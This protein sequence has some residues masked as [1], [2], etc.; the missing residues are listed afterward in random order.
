M[1][2]KRKG[3]IGCKMISRARMPKTWVA[4]CIKKGMKRMGSKKKASRKGKK[5]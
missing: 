2:K 1:F 4:V 3:S 5:F